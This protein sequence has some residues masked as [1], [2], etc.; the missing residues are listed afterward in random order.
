[1]ELRGDPLHCGND[2]NQKPRSYPCVM[3]S[4]GAGLVFCELLWLDASHL[5][6]CT[7]RILRRA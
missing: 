3:G 1:V 4:C 2:R 7:E 5:S 6:I